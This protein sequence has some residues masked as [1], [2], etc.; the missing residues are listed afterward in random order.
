MIPPSLTLKTMFHS[1]DCTAACES[2]S[3][4]PPPTHI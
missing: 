3:I 4:S 2:Q 1:Y